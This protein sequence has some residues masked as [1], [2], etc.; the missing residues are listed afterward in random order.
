MRRFVRLLSQQ[1]DGG[2]L[3]LC[4]DG[5]RARYGGYADAQCEGREHGDRAH[6]HQRRQI[7][8]LARLHHRGDYRGDG[9]RHNDGKCRR[10]KRDHQH[11]G[12]VSAVDIAH[13]HPQGAEYA[14]PLFGVVYGYGNEIDHHERG[15]HRRPDDETEDDLA[16]SVYGA[17]D[18]PHF[19]DDDVIDAIV[20]PAAVH[21]HTLEEISVPRFIGESDSYSDD[22]ILFL[23][24]LDIFA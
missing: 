7:D 8:E 18:T 24:K 4:E 5:Q 12:Y 22:L 1:V 3:Y 21:I 23:R 2:F 10:D 11:L 6:G 17:V 15:K 20:A 13:P 9:S 16:R 14:H 19:R